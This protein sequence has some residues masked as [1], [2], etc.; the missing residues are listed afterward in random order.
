MDSKDKQVQGIDQDE[1]LDEH[2][3]DQGRRIISQNGLGVLVVN[4]SGT[5]WIPDP[6]AETRVDW[7]P[8]L[9]RMAD[10]PGCCPDCGYPF[11]TN[12]DGCDDGCWD[13]GIQTLP[14]QDEPPAV[15]DYARE[16]R[17][18]DVMD[19]LDVVSEA[20]RR[21]AERDQAANSAENVIDGLAFMDLVDDGVPAVWGTG[22]S[23]L[24]AEGES[25]LLVGPTGV[26]KTT[27]TMQL[28]RALLVGGEVLGLPVEPLGPGEKILYLACDRP[29]QIA[30]RMRTALAGVPPGRVLEALSVQLG[31]PGMLDADPGLLLRMAR[32]HNAT[33]VIVDS[34]KD[35]AS[36]VVGDKAGVAINSA[37]QKCLAAGVDVAAMHHL[38]KSGG[39]NG[40]A[41]T[42]IEDVYGSTFITGGAGSVVLLWGEPGA[43]DVVLKHLKQPAETVGPLDVRHDHDKCMSAVVGG[44]RG[45][46]G[47]AA[48]GSLDVHALADLLDDA[49]LS[50][51]LSWRAT[52]KALGDL[53][54]NTSVV[55]G[56]NMAR[57]IVDLRKPPTST[58]GNGA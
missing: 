58:A 14:Q 53:P 34:L 6:S 13:H 44:H 17:I 56:Q 39:P 21:I 38:R 55:V 7:D 5:T 36:D 32:H 26:G 20:K 54:G 9:A 31:S 11:G 25:L 45:P 12:P 50:V 19:S 41:P 52:I 37:F 2:R 4:A 8:D 49:G 48:S 22:Q 47:G 42:K 43:L 35:M 3:D 16:G 51:N 57:R 33:K 10:Q 29:K 27:L 40:Q 23:V 46:V 18:T 24:W 30:R 28:L 15:I 1:Y